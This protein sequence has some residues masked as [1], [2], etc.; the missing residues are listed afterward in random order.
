MPTLISLNTA[1][2]LIAGGS[3]G[4]GRGLAARYVA[5]GARVLV[6][7]RSKEKLERVAAG[8]KV[9]ILVNEISS[10]AEREQL[11][12][13][14]RN[15]MPGINILINN[16]GIQRRVSLAQDTSSWGE[17]QAEID[18]LLCGQS[19]AVFCTLLASRGLHRA[20]R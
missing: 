19:R 15:V 11:A 10:P 9:E 5:H 7:G 17:R 1:N 2:V 20:W 8:L 13:H 4:I 14:V 12:V 3:E 6:T 18:T 16:A